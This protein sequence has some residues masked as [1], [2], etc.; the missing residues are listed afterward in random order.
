MYRI[1]KI[2]AKQIL[3]SRGKPTIETK[4]FLTDGSLGSSS[5]PSG[6]S[7]GIYEAKPLKAS[8][9]IMSVNNAINKR[10]TGQIANQKVIDESMLKLDGT[11]DKSKLGAN[12]I[13]SVSLATARAIAKANNEELYKYIANISKTKKLKVPIPFFNILNGGRHA[14]NRLKIQEFMIAPIKA[15]SFSEGM[16][17]ANTTFKVLKDIVRKKYGVKHLK[18]GDEGGFAPPINKAEEALDLLM[19]ALE[20]SNNLKKIGIAIDVAASEFYK[21]GEYVLENKMS[22]EQLINYYLK[23]IDQYPIISLE[24]PFQQH[25]FNSFHKLNNKLRTSRKKIQIVGD[26]LLVTN[27]KRI[28]KAV[29]YKSCNALLLKP[30]QIGSLSEAINA[31]KMAKKANWNV[32]VSHRSGETMDSFIADLSVGI[33]SGQIKSGAPSKP[34]R[35]VKYK[36]LLAIEKELGK[37]ARY[38]L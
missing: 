32:M 2:F 8:N 37:K 9:A 18:L 7:T 29:K 12:A 21:K 19:E 15:K 38:G 20:K 4:V 22:S 35:L 23:L 14:N 16:E 10:L 36:R 26:D 17:I 27:I 24:D 11:K 33:A 6:A 5:V 25:A 34:E 30:N 31:G 13:L 1:K 28:K 3:D